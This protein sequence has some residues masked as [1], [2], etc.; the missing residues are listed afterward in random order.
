MSAFINTFLIMLMLRNADKIA[1]R[2]QL[3]L[4]FKKLKQFG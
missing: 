4:R 2:V 1:R 3:K